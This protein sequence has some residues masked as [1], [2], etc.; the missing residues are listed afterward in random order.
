M[1]MK[2][3][4]HTIELPRMGNKVQVVCWPIFSCS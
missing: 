1:V 2:I 4:L 3:L